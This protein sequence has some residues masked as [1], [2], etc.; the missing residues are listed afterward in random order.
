MENTIF[1]NSS[2]TL[3]ARANN[4]E[5]VVENLIRRIK[6]KN[7]EIVYVDFSNIRSQ[8]KVYQAMDYAANYIRQQLPR[9]IYTLTNITGMYF[10]TDIFNRISVY[11]KQNEPF[12]KGSAVVG[13]SGLMQ[14]FYNSFSRISGREVKA[15]FSEE[16]AKEFLLNIQ[17]A[18]NLK[19]AQ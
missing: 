2:R 16:E 14:I 19:F 9:S 11:A 8:E 13:M 15:F 10:N 1:E 18:N 17:L 6:Y 3:A 12:V 5:L 4:N 7:I